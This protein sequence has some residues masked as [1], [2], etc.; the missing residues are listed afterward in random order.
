MTDTKRRLVQLIHRHA[1]DPGS[2]TALE[3]GGRAVTYR[4]LGKLTGE[5]TLEL[6]ALGVRGTFVALERSKSVEFVVDFLAV[7]AA[8]GTV[9]PV[10]PDTPPDRRAVFLELA[11]P[12]FLLGETG[13]LRLGGPRDR[14]VPRD[15]AFVYFTSGSTG[16]PKPVLG[17]AAAVAGFAEWFG[18]EFGAGPRDRFAF[19]TGLSFEA[20]LRDVFPPLVAGATLVLPEEGAADEPEAAVAWLARRDV[21]V[22]T[23][24]PSTARAWLAHGRTVC[25]AV[26]AVFF[27]GE[28]P[29]ADLLGG[30]RTLFPNTTLRVNS[31]GSTESGQAT[32][33]NR[34]A[35][36]ER[37]AAVPAGRPVPGTRYCFVEPG[38]VLDAGL[39]RERLEHPASGGEIVLVSRSCSHGYLGMPQENAARFADL[40]DGVT[41]YRTGDLGHVDAGGDLVVVGRADDE[42]KI[43][44]VRVHPAEVLRAVRAHRSVRDAFVTATRAEQDADGT[45]TRA[46]LTAYVV[47]E[48]DLS[49]VDLRRDL[50]DALPPAMIPARFVEV[51][52]LP[53]TRTGKVDRAALTGLAERAAG[54]VAP[55]GDVEPRVAAQ[56]AELLGAE[57]VSAAD[58]LFTLGGD[59][60]TAT[61][62]VSRLWQEFGVRLSQRDV[63]AAATV[64]GIAALIMERWLLAED[65]DELRA[66]LD[67]LEGDGGLQAGGTS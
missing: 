48:G 22:V 45:R 14:G 27:V 13:V 60:I 54:F 66:L 1:D 32:V 56:F 35:D 61:R 63:F 2:G 4:E 17:S 31:Y 62:L 26:R 11:A 44:G 18:P 40:G 15:A 8:G 49:V 29:G 16:T 36:D 10:D 37:A 52:E 25:P 3:Q 6:E 43:N 39:V 28:P 47:P 46:H 58:D 41:A 64:A 51:A 20:A 50:L 5:R 30:W 33:Y 55:S 9:V 34:I 19:L 12:E 67:A 38:A 21:S 24:V 59:S 65:P 7:L 53:R 57:R 23:V 42:I